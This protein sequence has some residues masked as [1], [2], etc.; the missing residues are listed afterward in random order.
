MG[1]PSVSIFIGVIGY[2]VAGS[3][4]R[5]CRL[6]VTNLE[7]HLCLNRKFL[8]YLA[9][10]DWLGCCF[11]DYWMR[12]VASANWPLPHC[13][14]HYNY[15]S[16]WGFRHLPRLA[17]G[18][19]QISGHLLCYWSETDSPYHSSFKT[20]WSALNCKLDSPLRLLWYESNSGQCWAVYQLTLLHCYC[21]CIKSQMRN[22]KCKAQ[23]APVKRSAHASVPIVRSR[24]RCAQSRSCGAL[25]VAGRVLWARFECM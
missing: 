12:W 25:I 5:I 6:C 7:E 14:H 10:L 1:N 20:A 2:K 16:I 17:H 4:I 8:C 22:S 18:W 24:A 15:Y 13:P 9:H 19:V 21:Y 23:V 3:S 11:S